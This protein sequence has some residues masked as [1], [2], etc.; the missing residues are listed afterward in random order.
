M[1]QTARS[2]GVKR[3][4]F[5]RRLF[6]I[7]AVLASISS[8]AYYNT[9]YLARK[10]YYRGTAGA[11]YAVDGGS[12]ANSA[13]FSKSI[14]YSKKVLGQ[15]PK[16]KWVDDAYLLWAQA[17][18]GKDDPIQTV[19]MLQDFATR[20]PKSPLDPEAMFFLG[21][22]NRQS[23]RNP[24][25]LI[26]LDE[27]LR[28][29]PRHKLAPHAHLERARALAALERPAE[30]AEAAGV[31]LERYPKSPM[32][33]RALALRA[34]ARLASGDYEPARSDF[35]ALGMQAMSDD[36]RLGFLLR[37]ADCLEAGRLYDQEIALLKDAISHEPE[38]PVPDTTGGKRPAAPAG[39]AAQR[40]G[41]LMVRYG[42]AELLAGNLEAALEAYGRVT[43][44]YPKTELAA[45]AQYRIGFSKETVAEDFDAAR[46]EYGRVREVMSS[47]PSA[48]LATQ[49]LVNLDRLSQ[50]RTA[51]GDSLQKG[52]EAGFLLAELYLFTHE[53]PERALVEYRRVENTYDG[54]AHAAKAINAQA[55]VLS[56]KLGREAEAESLFWR[57]V[58]EYPATEEQLAARDY[59][60]FA[61]QVV[62][63]TLIKLP[64]PKAPPRDTAAALPKV[65]EG[66]APIGPTTLGR[67]PQGGDSLRIGPRQP[68]GV[69]QMPPPPP[70]A[71]A[72]L[73]PAVPLGL[74]A[75]DSAAARDTTRS[76]SPPDTSRTAAPPD[77]TRPAAPADTTRRSPG[78][79]GTP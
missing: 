10:Y 57:V 41:R 44:S 69:L 2:K 28:G 35:R 63:D 30:A 22:G 14:D 16:S 75:G 13:Q 3:R 49:R 40:W 48:T 62:P 77:T 33:G 9:Y 54:T 5:A 25:A 23:R 76:A 59:L 19:N 8:C 4:A 79:S 37:E 36:E 6:A 29:A 52:A 67:L 50:F 47:G 53:K 43:R 15:Y 7:A 26:A 39:S 51:G 72:A 46:I 56:R 60:E 18:L 21:V 68:G 65:P 61:G 24:E 45:E 20:F 32:V 34:E 71:A 70:G 38:T 17:L 64:P 73:V 74:A 11:P 55:W 31:I 42:S 66:P 78:T 58:R 27:F 12:Q 1:P